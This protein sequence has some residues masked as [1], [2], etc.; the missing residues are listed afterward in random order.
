MRPITCRG[1]SSSGISLVASRWSNGKAI[2]F[3]LREKL[4]GELPLGELTRGDGFEHVA[5]VK[6]RIGTGDLDGLVPDGRLQAKLGTPVELDEGGFPG[7]LINRKLCTP[8]ASIMRSERGSVR[9]DMI[10]IIMCID[11]G[12]SEMKS[13]K[14][15]WAAADCGKPRSGSIF[16]AW[17]RSGT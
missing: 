1:T 13:Q 2:G 12:V 11:S 15:S 4:H 17:T 6:V 14:V 9:S 10:H 3:L 8:K 5:A 7:A 16:T